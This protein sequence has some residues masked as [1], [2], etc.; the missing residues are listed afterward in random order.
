M[1]VPDKWRMKEADKIYSFIDNYSFAT[2]ISG[3]LDASHLPLLLKFQ[4]DGIPVL[5]GHFSKANT[6]IKQIAQTRVL[7]VFHGPHAYISPSW[8]A[9]KPA[10]PTWNYAAVHV[11]GTVHLTDGDE[12]LKRL[13][14]L[15]QKY[16]PGL[17]AE[18][19]SD[20]HK[21]KLLNGIVGFK[22]V[23]DDI[24]AK[25]KLGQHKSSEDQRG[26]THGLANECGDARQLLEYMRKYGIGTGD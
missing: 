13:D 20:E 18:V 15:I 7:A 21:N 2:V 24:Q 8:Y 23:V 4:S 9:N 26:V 1:Y 3:N 25:E 19:I 14:Q 11:Q 5:Y 12:T 6:Q 17:S 10:V 22:I 16:D